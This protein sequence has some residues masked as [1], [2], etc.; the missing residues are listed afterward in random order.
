MRNN[1]CC[2]TQGWVLGHTEVS[3]LQTMSS[4]GLELQCSLFAGFWNTL[5][6]RHGIATSCKARLI[7]Q[8]SMWRPVG[9]QLLFTVMLLG[10]RK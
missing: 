4:A 6:C 2:E 9:L 1:T 10:S 3:A 5:L 8:G 7:L